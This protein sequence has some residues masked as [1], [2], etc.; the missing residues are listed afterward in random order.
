MKSKGRISN[1]CMLSCNDK[2]MGLGGWQWLFGDFFSP[3]QTPDL[4][5]ACTCT[6]WS[7]GHSSCVLLSVWFTPPA[8]P[9]T[10][11][12]VCTTMNLSATES[13]MIRRTLTM[14]MKPFWDRKRLRPLTSSH[15]KRARRGSGNNTVFC[16]FLKSLGMFVIT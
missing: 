13:T 8:N 4:D 11:R 10:R 3:L 12:T 16:F 1:D 5:G 15:Q 9:Q 2:E 14:T 6:G 7:C